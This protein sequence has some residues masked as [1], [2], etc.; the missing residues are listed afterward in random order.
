MTPILGN[1]FAKKLVSLAGLLVENVKQVIKCAGF[2][3]FEF[4]KMSE[5]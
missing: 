3:V 5:L 4:Q 1:L 2:F